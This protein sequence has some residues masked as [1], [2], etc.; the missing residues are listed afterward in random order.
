MKSVYFSS[1]EVNVLLLWYIMGTV[2]SKWVF[3]N[4][5]VICVTISLSLAVL[6]RAHI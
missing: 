5:L 1:S 3:S 2:L 6:A 4:V